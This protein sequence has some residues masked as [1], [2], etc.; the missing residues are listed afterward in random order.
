MVHF[1]MA[2][3]LYDGMQQV[4]KTDGRDVSCR[5]RTFFLTWSNTNTLDY[6]SF[7]KMIVGYSTRLTSLKH[8]Y[9][10]TIII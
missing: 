3:S 6:M 8:D 9:R 2:L 10:D 7:S 4:M 5:M 1:P